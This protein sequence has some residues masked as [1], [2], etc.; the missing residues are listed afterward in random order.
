[1][2]VYNHYQV[3]QPTTLGS[4]AEVVRVGLGVQPLSALIIRVRA[5]LATANTDDN[6]DTFL[7]KVDFLE[8]DYRGTRLISGRFANLVALSR[9]LARA[10][11]RFMAPGSAAGSPRE[12]SVLLP[13]GR[14]IGDPH[15]CLP[16]VNKGDLTLTLRTIANPSGYNNW[17]V[18][19][20]A[21]ELPDA[22]PTEFY[23]YT[24]IGLMPT[25]SGIY[26]IDL[27]R[28]L[29]LAGL[30]IF[31][32]PGIPFAG[33]NVVTDVELLVNNAEQYVSF[34]SFEA[35]RYMAQHLSGSS[36]DL[37]VHRHTENTGAS[38]A[39]NASTLTNRNVYDLHDGFGFISFDLTGD[40]QYLLE[41]ANLNNLVLRANIGAVGDVR[42]YP[43]EIGT[44][45]WLFRRSPLTAR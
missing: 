13:F 42:V 25:T 44:D 41:T 33:A 1:M 5:N 21:I 22:K 10:K 19:V 4:G 16:A 30:G 7:S 45:G 11:P 40:D 39:Q 20:E 2:A 17:S 36:A 34:A 35:L 15:R 32:A 12:V 9:V 31:T 8:V 18:S 37:S 29:K 6:L 3:L 23:R 26:D 43:I 24:M 14:R 28:A 27:P 38:Y